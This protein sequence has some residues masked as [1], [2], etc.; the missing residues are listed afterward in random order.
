MNRYH[1]PKNSPSPSGEGAGGEV[2]MPIRQPIY[3]FTNFA[4]GIG[5][6]PMTA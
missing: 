6:Q 5:F 4:L 3:R 2:K 1:I